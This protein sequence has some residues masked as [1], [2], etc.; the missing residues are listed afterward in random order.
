M[1]ILE[2]NR[3]CNDPGREVSREVTRES[4]I[5]AFP[6]RGSGPV[7]RTTYRDFGELMVSSFD[8]CLPPCG[9]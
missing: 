3:N 6:G 2:T 4:P 7:I 9:Q 1:S 5:N 8:F